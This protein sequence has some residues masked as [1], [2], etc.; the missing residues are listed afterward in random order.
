MPETSLPLLIIAIAFSGCLAPALMARFGRKIS[1]LC[2]AAVMACCL[3]FLIPAIPAVLAGDILVSSW[4]WLP[5]YGLNL[6][7]RLDGL[8]LLFCL[9]ILCIGLLVVLYAHY[10]LPEKDRLGRFHSFLLL[11]MAAMLGVVLSENLLLLVVFWEITSI[12]SFLLIAYKRD[13]YESRIA[14]RMALAVTGGGGLALFAG[15]LLLG[16][17]V[18]SFELSAV[19]AEGERIRSHA[20]YAPMLILTL[21]GVFTKSAQ[22]PFHFWQI[23]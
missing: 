17:I 2:A 9:L 8:G 21:L 23:W 4:T 10:Y 12:S 13:Q 6:A 1:T 7:F 20:L 11:F 22:F 5:D 14:A 16:H 15:V 3:S 19:L 18:G